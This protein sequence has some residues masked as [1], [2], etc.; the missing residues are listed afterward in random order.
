MSISMFKSKL[1]KILSSILNSAS[2][3]GVE[4]ISAFPL[5]GYH[6]EK[7]P[8][9]RVRTWNHYDRYNALKAIRTVGMYT[10]SDDLNCQ[11][12]YRKEGTYLFQ[13]SVNNY[14]PISEDD[15]NNPLFSSA[16]LRDRT[17]VLTWDIETYS[18]RKTGEVP[19]AKY[20]EDVVF[21]ICMTVHWKDDPEPLK[22]ICLVDVEI[23]PDPRW[24]T[25]V[26]E[27]QTNLLKAFALCWKLLA[28]DIQI[29]FND[30]QYDWKFIVEKANKLGV[31]KW[32][33]NHMSF[34]PSSL[35]KIIITLIAILYYF[36]LLPFKEC[37][38]DNKVDLPIHRMNKYYEM[39]LKETNA[40]TAEQMHEVAKYCIIDALSCQRLMVKHNAINKYREVASVAFLSLFDA[41]YFAGGMKVCNLLSASAWQ[42]GI[43]TSMISS[44]QTETGKFPGA[45]VFPPVKGLEN[46]RPVTGLDFASLYPSL[47]MSY[48]LSPNKII[49]F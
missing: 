32:M 16:L 18:S 15:Y 4:T 29:G 25:I 8:Y 47:I 28:P 27:S 39:A 14:N 37:K 19:N 44:Q 35:E 36:H 2:K 43:L 10:A 30:S 7:K 48:N 21:M 5:R 1:V 40:T 20:E 12:Y 23:A 38:L 49:L 17:L 45:Y 22:Q 34:K 24:I 31:L 46:R 41:H 26:C 3:F 13:V 9:I 42:R 6:T 33:F 11:Y